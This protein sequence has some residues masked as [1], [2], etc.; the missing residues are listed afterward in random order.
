MRQSFASAKYDKSD[1]SLTVVKKNRNTFQINRYLNRYLF[2]VVL[3]V[4][5]PNESQGKYQE[6][7]L[8][9]INHGLSRLRVVQTTL[10]L[11]SMSERVGSDLE[12]P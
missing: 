10:F 1:E 8:V 3:H 2:P 6:I 11:K 12:R 5:K 9:R 7:R 4:F